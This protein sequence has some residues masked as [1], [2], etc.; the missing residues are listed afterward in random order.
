[1]SLAAYKIPSACLVETY[2]YLTCGN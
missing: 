1:M 2:S